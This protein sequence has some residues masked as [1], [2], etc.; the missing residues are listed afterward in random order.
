MP[1][2]KIPVFI[3]AGKPHKEAQIIFLKKF[4][5]LLRRRGLKPLTLGRSSYNF[6]SPLNPV[7][8]L[9]DQCYGAIII[10]FERTHC[11]IGYDKEGSKEQKEFIHRY[12]STPWNQIEAGMAFQKELPLL[13][14]KEKHLETY[15]ILDPKLSGFFVID[16]NLEIESKKFDKEFLSILES[17]VKAVKTYSS[18]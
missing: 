5:A 17:W 6:K 13:I 12:L 8:E 16:L 2:N 9:I 14:M 7:K 1:N 4:E 15:G 10:G 11:L 18:C 3:S